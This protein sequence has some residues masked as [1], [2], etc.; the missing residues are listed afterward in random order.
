MLTRSCFIFVTFSYFDLEILRAVPWQ[1]FPG[2]F[3]LIFGFYFWDVVY[4]VYR[5]IKKDQEN[6]I[7][8]QELEQLED[9]ANQMNP[10]S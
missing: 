5:D 7:N 2:I 8:E 3:G 4:S 1:L 9:G 10:D 6:E